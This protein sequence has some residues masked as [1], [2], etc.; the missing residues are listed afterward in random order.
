MSTVVK[1][2]LLITYKIFLN[3]IPFINK[4]NTKIVKCNLTQSSFGNPFLKILAST[5]DK[6]RAGNI[7]AARQIQI[8]NGGEQSAV[9]LLQFQGTLT[10]N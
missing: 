7:A 8:A 5:G 1:L 10:E 2:K 4:N 9:R 3:I 6:F